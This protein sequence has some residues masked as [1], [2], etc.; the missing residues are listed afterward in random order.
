MDLGLKGKTAIVTGGS[1]GIGRAVALALAR[2]GADVSICARGMSEL[3]AAAA[4]VRA[5]TGQR[6]LP[7]QADM[8]DP[9]AITR[10]VDA[11]VN[12]LGGG[13]YPDK[14]RG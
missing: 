11:T 12:E 3:E 5:E 8:N 13:G 2:E 4:E 6:I 1:K 9:A 10:M 7:V 14:Q